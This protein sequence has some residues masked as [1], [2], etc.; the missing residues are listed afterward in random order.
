MYG[1]LKEDQM[2]KLICISALP[3]F[4][5]ILQQKP[6]NVFFASGS[7]PPKHLIE[8]NTGIALHE[9][10]SFEAEPNPNQHTTVLR[11]LDGEMIDFS[12]KK[13]RQL[14]KKNGED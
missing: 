10:Y 13:Q 3:A 1:L 11:K 12:Y 6:R 5:K 4:S 9:E 2:I 8:W 14:K 7:L